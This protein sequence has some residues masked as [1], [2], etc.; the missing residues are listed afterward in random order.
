MTLKT[1]TLKTNQRSLALIPRI[2][3]TSLICHAPARQSKSPRGNCDPAGTRNLDKRCFA[4]LGS[5]LRK[6]MY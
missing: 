2:G 3:A 6:C 1:M 5:I 4:R